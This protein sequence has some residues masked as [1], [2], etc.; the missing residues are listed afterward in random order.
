MLM[1]GKLFL[2]KKSIIPKYSYNF[3]KILL[4]RTAATGTALELGAKTKSIYL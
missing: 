4:I 1:E 2:P 3:F